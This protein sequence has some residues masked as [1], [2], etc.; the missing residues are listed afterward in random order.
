MVSTDPTTTL[1]YLD[2]VD[3]HPYARENDELALH[4]VRI[5]GTWN[6]WL[7]PVVT[8]SEFRR[9]IS[10][11]ANNDPRGSWSPSGVIERN[12]YLVYDD[13]QHDDPD[14]WARVG[15]NPVGQALYTLE[16]WTW[17]A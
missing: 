12:G 2:A 15:T 9:F 14:T 10:A 3:V 8:A 17:R 6:G 7:V 11:N 5:D 16:G 4:A 13:R 1:V